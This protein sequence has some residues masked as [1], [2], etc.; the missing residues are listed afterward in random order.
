MTASDL[1]DL[2]SVHPPARQRDLGKSLRCRR[3]FL[4]VFPGGFHDET[5]LDWERDYKWEAHKRWE[6]SLGREH[7]RELLREQ[8]FAEIAVRAVTVEQRT[9]H[10]LLFS[11]EKMALRD[12]VRTDR[13]ART[14]S[15]GLY[16]FLHGTGE[17]G[18][19]FA[20]WVK[21]VDALPRR[22]T[23]V[24]TWPMVT[25]WGFLAQPRTHIFFKP[26]VTRRAAEHYGR[27]LAYVSRPNWS[28]YSELLQLA[29]VVRHDLQDMRPRDMI[30]IQSFLWV[31]GS[32]EY[33]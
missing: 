11:F 18:Y 13:G 12:A 24:L 8:H 14:F 23:R 20:R 4:K 3:R 25:V 33:R 16:R 10:S 22:Q 5:Y 32:D 2:T 6:A 19:R 29:A 9:R 17:P 28:T 26:V 21:D 15:E 7:F 30:D 27:P 1:S 31:Q